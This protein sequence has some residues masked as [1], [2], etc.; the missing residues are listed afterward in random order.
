M[1]STLG[2]PDIVVLDPARE[3]AGTE[4]MD[5]LAARSDS[6]RTLIYVS[7]DPSSIRRCGRFYPLTAW[8][9]TPGP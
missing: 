1:R 8:R 7:C 2:R 4:V 9:L 5:A 3:G 6:V